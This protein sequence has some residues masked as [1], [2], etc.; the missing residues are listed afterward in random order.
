M[1]EDVNNKYKKNNDESKK[2][3]GILVEN[4]AEPVPKTVMIYLEKDNQYL[5]LYRNKKEVDI[6]K[7][8]YIGVGGHVEFNETEDQAVVRE[9]KEET[10][11]DLLSFRKRGLVYFVLNGYV[12]AMYI[13]TSSDFKGELIEC[14]EGD[15]SWVDK[16]KVSQLNLWEGDI[17]FLKKI[18]N[19]EPY[20]EMK[21]I[22][23]DDILIDKIDLLD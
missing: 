12:E 3:L 20:F 18:L 16:D 4:K 1:V 6:N 22:Y 21:L 13:Y 5:M 17:H 14:N 2:T 23:K 8:K 10:G 7:G 11:L 15:L 9:V 19:D